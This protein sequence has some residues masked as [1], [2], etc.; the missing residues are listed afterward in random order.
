MLKKEYK[1]NDPLTKKIIQNYPKTR[2]KNWNEFKF[3]SACGIVFV[4][5]ENLYKV[6]LVWI[7][8]YS[9][10]CLNI[11]EYESLHLL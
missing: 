4:H 3:C 11:F 1:L 7:I 2:E 6:N 10:K 8:L 9:N 5:R